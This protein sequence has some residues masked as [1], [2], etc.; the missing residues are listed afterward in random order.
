MLP[1]LT[2]PSSRKTPLP[3]WAESMWPRMTEGPVAPGVAE[4]LY[5][6]AVRTSLSGGTCTVLS[7][8]R[9][10]CMM[11]ASTPIAG[12][13]IRMGIDPDAVIV[14]SGVGVAGAVCDG[15]GAEVVSCSVGVW[16]MASAAFGEGAVGG[17]LCAVEPTTI[18]TAPSASSSAHTPAMPA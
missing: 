17:F 15:G 13:V 9:P 16:M 18:R 10:S 6:P 5:Q 11:L 12:T 8:F 1:C 7:A 2:S 3:Y 4:Y 14:G